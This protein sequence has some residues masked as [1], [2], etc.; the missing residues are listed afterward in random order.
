MKKMIFFM[1]CHLTY[2]QADKVNNAIK[3]LMQKINC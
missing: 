2:S 3:D 1:V